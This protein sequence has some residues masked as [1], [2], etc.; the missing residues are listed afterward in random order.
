ME[1]WKY[2]K[3]MENMGNNLN[4]WNFMRIYEKNMQ[5]NINS[6]NLMNIYEKHEISWKFMKIHGI[7]LKICKIVW[8][9]I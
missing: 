7:S 5:N 9:F 1:K 4:S 3:F 6:L 2:W 8:N